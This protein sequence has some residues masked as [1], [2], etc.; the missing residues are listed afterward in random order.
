M[1]K[2]KANPTFKAKVAIPL[3]GEG[4]HNLVFEFK[5]KRRGE[6]A[7][8]IKNGVLDTKSDLDAVLDICVGWEL[9]EPFNRENV[10]ELLEEYHGAAQAIVLTWGRELSGARLGN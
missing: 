10:E 6:F 8:L 3:P 4:F 5:H 1:F 9:A 7:E 2:I